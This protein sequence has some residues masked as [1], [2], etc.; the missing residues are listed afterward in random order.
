MLARCEKSCTMTFGKRKYD[1]HGDFVSFVQ[2]HVKRIQY[3]EHAMSC[4]SC[5]L[6]LARFESQPD[7]IMISRKAPRCFQR[8]LDFR[9]PFPANFT[10][11]PIQCASVAYHH[12]CGFYPH[13]QATEIFRQGPVMC[14]QPAFFPIRTLVFFFCSFF[15][16]PYEVPAEVRQRTPL[17]TACFG[18]PASCRT[19]LSTFY[20]SIAFALDAVFAKGRLETGRRCGV[21]CFGCT[22][23]GAGKA[24]LM[25]WGENEVGKE[26]RE[27]P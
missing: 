4:S 17:G 15:I 26:K 10:E 3:A 16:Q 5:L 25:Q 22:L 27:L 20:K 21:T 9:K 19:C 11:T 2:L 24:A 13:V 23:R 1:D 6:I 18:L 7:N 14:K 12:S 8:A